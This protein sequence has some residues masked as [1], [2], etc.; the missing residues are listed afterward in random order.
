MVV[1]L[2]ILVIYIGRSIVILSDILDISLVELKEVICEDIGWNC[3]EI[4]VDITWR[5]QVMEC[6]IHYVAMLFLWCQ[7]KVYG[8]V[9][10]RI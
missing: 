8:W 7:F 9:S 6:P 3:N 10:H 1:Q 5:M 4:K 2:L